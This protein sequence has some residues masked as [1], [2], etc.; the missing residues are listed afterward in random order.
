MSTFLVRW[1]KL[2]LVAVIGCGFVAMLIYTLV[3]RDAIRNSQ[4]E[5][6]LITPPDQPLKRRPDQPGGM[7]IP[8][9][10]KLVFDLL[11]NNVSS[12]TP[13]A[14]QQDMEDDVPNG[15]IA[16]S[17]S[18]VMAAISSTIQSTTPTSVSVAQP[19]SAAAPVKQAEPAPAKVEVVPKTEPTKP[20][21]SQPVIGTPAKAAST[22]GWGVQVAAV[23]SK[24]DG[25][26]AAANLQKSVSGLAGLTPHI[27]A[28][29][30]G[31]HYRVQF[32]GLKSRAAAE[33]LC[34][35]LKAAKQPCF[36][37]SIL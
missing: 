18:D 17:G 1:I 5:P 34:T 12:A 32:G 23:G 36:P 13:A 16:V 31:K 24:A 6:P 4:V 10:D 15:A 20:V 33:A 26:K 27:E 7:Q 19:V 25:D 37:V 29:P 8:N 14:D 35:K 22:G 28:T 30:D 9:R 3:N 21:T 2:T 11:D